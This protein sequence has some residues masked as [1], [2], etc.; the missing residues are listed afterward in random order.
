MARLELSVDGGT[1]TIALFWDDAEEAGESLRD[2]LCGGVQM[3]EAI[4]TRG[5]REILTITIDEPEPFVATAVLENDVSCYEGTDGKGSVTTNGNPRQF[6]WSNGAATD[7]I[8]QLSGGTYRVTVTNADGCT[9]ETELVIREPEAPL[10]VGITIEKEVS[11][12]NDGDGALLASVVGPGTAF[13]YEW[14]NGRSGALAEGLISGEYGVTVTNEKGC[15]AVGCSF[16]RSAGRFT[17]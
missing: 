7:V 6:A 3:V 2:D 8:D 17:G 13:E 15:E 12:F 16:P 4:D 9:A 14:T 1:G 11:C 5:C 10:E